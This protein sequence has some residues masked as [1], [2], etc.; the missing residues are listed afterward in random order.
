MMA[1][2]QFERQLQNFDNEIERLKK[3]IES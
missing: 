1:Q 3:A 2:E